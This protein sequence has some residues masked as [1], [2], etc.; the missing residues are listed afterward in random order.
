MTAPQSRRRAPVA[1]IA[2]AA[3]VAALAVPI[4][5][6][7]D[8]AQAHRSR[9]HQRHICP[10]DHATYRWHGLLCVKPS[11]DENDGSFHKR[12]RHGGRTYYCKR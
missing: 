6:P 10:S 8:R 2:L 12:V 5:P 7:P 4:A 9:C 1:R 11:A 3:T